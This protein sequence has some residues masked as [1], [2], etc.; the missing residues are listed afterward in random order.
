M[1]NLNSRL[2]SVGL[3]MRSWKYGVGSWKMMVEMIS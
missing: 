3:K 1:K 2:I